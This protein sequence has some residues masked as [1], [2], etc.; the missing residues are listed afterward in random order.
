MWSLPNSLASIGDCT[1]EF[2]YSICLL[3]RSPNL[4]WRGWSVRLDRQ[5]INYDDRLRLD[6]FDKPTLPRNVSEVFE[7]ARL[8]SGE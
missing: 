6:V 7:F 8:D 3:Q 1:N 4:K 5:A 2:V